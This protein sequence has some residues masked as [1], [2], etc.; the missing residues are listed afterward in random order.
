MKPWRLKNNR[1]SLNRNKKGADVM[2][3]AD[4]ICIPVQ[5]M[6]FEK[7]MPGV[8]VNDF[9]PRNAPGRFLCRD[10]VLYVNDICYGE[11]Y[12]N[13]YLDIWYASKDTS[14]DRPTVIWIHG[15][16]FI[17]GDKVSG[18][19]LAQSMARNTNLCAAIA[20]RGY[21]VVSPNYAL[22][23]DYRF[24]VQL[25]QVDQIIAFLTAHQQEYGLDMEH[26]FLGGGSAGA[27]LAEIYGALLCNRDYADAVGFHPT[28]RKKQIL[29]LLIDE[30]ALSVRN[31]EANMNAMLGCWMGQDGISESPRA[32]LIDGS[33]WIREEYIPS[34]INSSNMEI[35][36]EDSAKDLAAVLERNGTEYEL[37]FRERMCDSL[38]HGYMQRF[39]SNPYAK[40]CFEH[41][42]AFMERILHQKA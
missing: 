7:T 23:P 33:K 14:V 5:K 22:A 16:G 30:A 24:P 21:N 2:L 3:I 32:D 11:M 29:G 42:L 27:N 18:D 10:G 17:F 38:E 37:F 34:F 13:S 20:K 31:F 6:V 41:M 4:A 39:A 40:E 12:P 8:R 25:E 35:F 1:D 19:P 26:V 28:I 15:G 36:F 9:E